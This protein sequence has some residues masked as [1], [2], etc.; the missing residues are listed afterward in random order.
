ME[1][2]KKYQDKILV[3]SVKTVVGIFNDP[4]VLSNKMRTS[5]KHYYHNR[6]NSLLILMSSGSISSYIIVWYAT[7]EHH[8]SYH[9]AQEK[10]KPHTINNFFSWHFLLNIGSTFS[11]LYCS[12]I[13]FKNLGG[14]NTAWILQA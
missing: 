9:E 4:E 10:N 8:K 11:G 3:F 6:T 2:K 12:K 14:K 7:A 13:P 5:E 1:E